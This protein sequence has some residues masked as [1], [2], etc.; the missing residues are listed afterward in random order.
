MTTT[1]DRA[2]IRLADRLTAEAGRHYMSGIQALVRLPLDVARRDRAAGVRTGV[3]VSGYPGSPLGGY[4]L[5]L[6][7]ERALLDEYGVVHYPAGNEEQAA[8]ACTGTQMLDD[9][10]HSDVEGVTAFWYG[11]GPGLDRSGDALKHGNF[12]GTSRLGAVVVLVGDD[13]EAKS[14][15]MPYQEEPALAAANP[16]AV[17]RHGRRVPHARAA[18][19]RDEPLQ[20]LLGGAQAGQPALGR[21]RDRRPRRAGRARAARPGN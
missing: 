14:S 18:R 16:R 9:H 5:A 8:T 13:H 6:A 1:T 21:R 7:R 10:P 15:T 11:K 19:G 3:F 20:R 12:A 17:P 2:P 4:D